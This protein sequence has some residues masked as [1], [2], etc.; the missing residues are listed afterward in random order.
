MFKQDANC[1]GVRF[2]KKVEFDG[3]TK[4][5]MGAYFEGAKFEEEANFQDVQFSKGADFE[6]TIFT[7]VANFREAGF[8]GTANYLHTTFI[9]EACFDNARFDTTVCFHEA[10]FTQKAKFE[11]VHFKEEADFR[12]SKF[13]N[14]WVSFMGS[15]FFQEA[16]FMRANFTAI[17]IFENVTFKRPAYFNNTTFTQ[18]ANFKDAKF[19]NIA[20]FKDAVFWE[21]CIF[22]S[23]KFLSTTLF[24]NGCFN[25]PPNFAEADIHADT[26]FHERE[27]DINKYIDVQNITSKAMRALKTAL[28]WLFTYRHRGAPNDDASR[29]W[30]VLKTNMNRLHNISYELIFFRYEL[31]AKINSERLPTATLIT[32]YKWSSIYGTSILLPLLWLIYFTVVFAFLYY[33]LMAEADS[34]LDEDGWINITVTNILPFVNSGEHY[35]NNIMIPLEDEPELLRKLQAFGVAQKVISL[36]FIFLAGLGLR[37]KLSIK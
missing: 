5:L 1:K 8:N 10:T 34:L 19:N 27:F 30:R 13:I 22:V 32:L 31:D 11:G 2:I 37:N 26:T 23:V 4:F 16:K 15:T 14:Q 29:A 9:Q 35:I 28:R 7:Q 24:S 20:D 36:I 3:H 12:C 17:A 18:S 33:G 6:D 25:K 21:T